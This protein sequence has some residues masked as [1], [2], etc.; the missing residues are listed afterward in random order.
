M[1]FPLQLLL[2]FLCLFHR[3][4]IPSIPLKMVIFFLYLK[5]VKTYVGWWT[6]DACLF[7]LFNRFARLLCIMASLTLVVKQYEWVCVY[8]PVCCGLTSCNVHFSFSKN[9][10]LF[11]I[12]KL[13]FTY[14]TFLYK[15]C[16][17]SI[18][19]VIYIFMWSVFCYENSTTGCYII[20]MWLF[21][22]TYWSAVEKL[23]VLKRYYILVVSL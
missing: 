17:Q 5:C 3:E 14:K 12:I 23:Y 7:D 13:A 4:W 6:M 18:K 15:L 16:I 8:K 9:V 2:I 1:F 21:S 10:C 20:I 11:F 22:I 19:Q